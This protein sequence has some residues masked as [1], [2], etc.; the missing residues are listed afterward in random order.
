M[1]LALID[2]AVWWLVLE[3]IGF[4][5]LPIASHI[6]RNLKDNGYSISKPLGLLLLTYISW[7][8]S[9]F[10][11]YSYFSVLLSLGII[12]ACSLIIYWKKGKLSLDKKYIVNFEILFFFLFTVFVFI[13]AYSPDIYWTGGE[14]FMDMTFINSFLRTSQFPPLDPWM[15][16]TVIQYYYFGYLIVANLI[17]ISAVLPSAAFNLATSSFFALAFTTA[18]GI[19]YNLTGRIKYGIITAFFVTTAGNLVGFFQL[20][21]ILSK[22]DV[23]NHILSFDY[24]TS[25]RVIPDTINEFPFFSFLQG[26]VHAHMISI[27]FQLLIL[28]LLLNIMKSRA[29]SCASIFILGLSIGFLYPLNTWDYPVYLF[30]AIIVMA[31]R[32]FIDSTFSVSKKKLSKPIFAICAVSAFSYLLYLPYHNSYRLDRTV[33]IIT[34][35]RTSL[36]F[37]IAIYGLFLYL[38]YRF[39]ISKSKKSGL[40]S[41]Y[42]VITLILLSVLAVSLKFE[43]L[44]LLIPMLILSIVSIIKEKNRDHAFVLILIITG[45]LLS[46]F[47]ELFYIQDAL[48]NAMPS[49]FRMNTVFKLY[50]M[51]WVLWGV[52]AGA[53]V[54]QFR[55]SFSRKKTWGIVAVLLILM[56]SV[57]PVFATIGKSGGFKGEPN[58]DGEAYVQKQHPQDYMAILWFRNLTGQPV[59]LQAP[60]ELYSWNTYITAFTGLPTVIGWYWHEL[61][62]RYPRRQEVD[63]RWSEVNTMYT[64]LNPEE[65]SSLLRKYNVSYI[66]FGEA[67]S[68]RYSSP[69][70]FES[71]PEKFEK[72]FEYGDVVI[73]KFKP[74][75]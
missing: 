69:R 31:F 52:S 56:V 66:Y 35:E 19:G 70:L 16:G 60:G 32:F 14:K 51:N 38:I 12:T 11:G 25:S 68:K 10:M 8:I 23:V 75:R 73:Y 41:V 5:A 55:D 49:Y 40:K 34:S 53:I 71:H 63:A 30:L 29:S 20:L 72:V 58:L 50:V 22:G 18:L 47:C 59:V 27:T 26:D 62:W 67:E 64:S 7:I 42:F 74:D 45:I 17:K 65:V 1:G 3:I 21:D 24:W 46:L 54:F 9:I 37:Y 44:I 36:I 61:N 39:V 43:L 48:G 15:S 13:R 33:S 4:C 28:L 6:S 2:I 57:Y